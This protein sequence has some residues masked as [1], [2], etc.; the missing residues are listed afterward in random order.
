MCSGTFPSQ[1][2]LQLCFLLNL[3]ILRSSYFIWQNFLCN[4]YSKPAEIKQLLLP[5][6]LRYR[7]FWV[8]SALRNWSV[9]MMD[10]F[11]RCFM[12]QG[13]RFWNQ[14]WLQGVAS[15]RSQA[16]LSSIYR[17]WGLCLVKDSLSLEQ[18]TSKNLLQM[19]LM[20]RMLVAIDI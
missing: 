10:L 7:M 3:H 20:P 8:E 2:G 9:S 18:A 11:W 15:D 4:L 6:G 5:R 1:T 16:Y 12:I 17:S 14:F 19:G 13:E